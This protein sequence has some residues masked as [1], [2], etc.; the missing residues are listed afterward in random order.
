MCSDILFVCE[1]WSR[2]RDVSGRKST[3]RIAWACRQLIEVKQ[4]AG[5]G[6]E[7]STE[8]AGVVGMDHPLRKTLTTLTL[9]ISTPFYC[10]ITNL[11]NGVHVSKPRFKS[12]AIHLISLHYH[13]LHTRQL[14][15][16]PPSFVSEHVCLYASSHLGGV[17]ASRLATII[18]HD[19]P[20]RD[21]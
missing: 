17:H 1:A 3:E 6:T 5:T 10:E 21:W 4:R 8:A 2:A 11:T 20:H 13:L 16:V 14:S 9:S 12:H 19:H 7:E 15:R 18:H